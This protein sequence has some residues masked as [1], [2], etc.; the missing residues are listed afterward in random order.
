MRPSIQKS[1]L[2]CV[3]LAL[4]AGC[5]KEG[6]FPNL[7]N[8]EQTNPSAATHLSGLEYRVVKAGT[9]KL[10]GGTLSGVGDIAFVKPHAENIR[11]KLRFQLDNRGALSLVSHSDTDLRTGLK[12]TFTRID[13]LVRFQVETAPAGRP[14][15][16]FDETIKIAELNLDASAEITLELDIHAHGHFKVLANGKES[17]PIGFRPVTANLAGLI[18]HGVAVKEIGI[19]ASRVRD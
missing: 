14:F 7:T 11:V 18:L 2:T 15:Q 6:F 5:G 17:L 9:L 1:I 4:L 8:E 19:A 12:L 16:G 10:D 13:K 3:F